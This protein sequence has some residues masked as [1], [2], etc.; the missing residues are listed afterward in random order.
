MASPGTVSE[1]PGNTIWKQNLTILTRLSAK[2]PPGLAKRTKL[3][4]KWAIPEAKD[5]DSD[6]TVSKSNAGTSKTHE[7]VSKMS[8][9]RSKR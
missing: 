5:D 3:S 4:A 1:V 6:E 8:D 7:T 2:A 9:P